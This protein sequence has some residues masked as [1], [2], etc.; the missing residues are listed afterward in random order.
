V[1]L[2]VGRIVRA[3]GIRGEVSVEVRT[4]D[5]DSRFTAGSVF[6]TD[7]A[8]S[9]PLTLLGARWHQGRLLA[10]FKEIPDRNAAEA[11]RGTSLL[12]DVSDD[13]RSEDPEE[14]YDHQLVGL[15]VFDVTGGRVG[16]V[17]EVLHNPHQE[18]LAIR[19][20]S[21]AEVLVPFVSAIVV[22]IDIEHG[23]LVIDPPPGLLNLGEVL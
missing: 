13:E 4:D 1:D 11:A 15:A 10:T 17:S 8:V 5:P 14:F 18:L 21:D 6:R 22:E 20:D 9:G 23:R 19:D 16:T 12:V 7:P 3:H 2:V